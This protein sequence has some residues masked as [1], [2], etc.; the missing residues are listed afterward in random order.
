MVARR[1]SKVTSSK[2][3]RM[4]PMR[5]SWVKNPLRGAPASPDATARIAVVLPTPGG[6]VIKSA[7]AEESRRAHDGDEGPALLVSAAGQA[8]ARLPASSTDLRDRSLSMVIVGHQRR[9]RQGPPSAG[10]TA[11][12]ALQRPVSSEGESSAQ[13]RATIPRMP[14]K[15]SGTG[16]VESRVSRE[17]AVRHEPE[18]RAMD[19]HHWPVLWPRDVGNAH[20]VP[21]NHIAVDERAVRLD[22]P[23]QPI[24]STSLIHELAGRVL[25]GRVIGGDPQVRLQEAGPH[26]QGRVRQEKWRTILSGLEDIRDRLAEYV[27]GPRVHDFPEAARAGIEL[28]CRLALAHDRRLRHAGRRDGS[29]GT[30]GHIHFEN[31]IGRTVHIHVE[32]EVEPVLMVDA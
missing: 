16:Y 15:S 6:P 9:Q 7:T 4:P 2:P 29:W 23:R 17:E 21:E 27:P 22:P 1:P 11:R 28:A 20:R 19:G 5:I 13:S 26:Q 8:T 3:R 32:T 18:A 31:G 12:A 14:M 10:Q 30:G 25:L 24:A